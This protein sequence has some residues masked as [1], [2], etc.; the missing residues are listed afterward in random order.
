MPKKILVVVNSLNIGG[1]ENHISQIFPRLDR[2][3]YQVIVYT[4]HEKG[5][6]AND[7]SRQGIP[8]YSS[9][10]AEWLHGLGKYAKPLAY[11]FS[12]LKLSQLNIIHR[13][14]I[15]H[16]YL[17]GAYLMGGITSRFRMSAHLV[18]SRRGLNNY[19]KKYPILT[20]LEKR[21]HRHCSMI[22]GNSHKVLNQLKSEVSNESQL[23]CIYNGI[24]TN[25]YQRKLMK[26]PNFFDHHFII[27]IVANLF[28]Y[29]GHL[30]LLKALALIQ[31]QLPKNWLLLCVGRDA[32]EL[33]SLKKYVD[34]HDLS[35]HVQWLGERNDIVDILSLSSIGVLCSH[36]EGFSN[37]ILEGMSCKV[38]M[39]VTDV[40]RKC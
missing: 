12:F 26:D 33:A 10:L 36:E 8:V 32:G 1:T 27:T 25:Q 2:D 22:L 30:D 13:P 9:L 21:M 39:V 11:F 17:P 28:A 20:K 16:C 23:S 7:L 34:Q 37:S 35:D 18:M 6:F 14:D 4:T 31:H 5:Y 15:I 38:P 19:Q 3:K 24:D 40:G 29:K